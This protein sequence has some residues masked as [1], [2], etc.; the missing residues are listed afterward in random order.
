M[1]LVT[2][3]MGRSVEVPE[4]AQRI[5]SLVP[6]QTEL[7]AD[8]GLEDEV[9]GITKF[10]VHPEKWFRS[11]A[12]IGG[13]KSVHTDRV[14]ALKPDL[15]IANKEENDKAQIEALECLAPVW[16]SD[17]RTLSEA[18]EMIRSIGTFCGKATEGNLIA[19]TVA[20]GFGALENSVKRTAAYGI[21]RAPWMWAGS[22]TF[23]N[24]LM[25]R[26]GLV[27]VLHDTRYPEVSL[28][29]LAALQ[30]DV[31]LLSSEPYPFKDAHITEVQSIL[32]EAKVALVDGEMFSWYGSRLLHAPEYLARLLQSL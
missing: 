13:T 5:V 1:P 11:K 31:V 10:C 2:D 8:L 3:M 26:C 18:L 22:D 4:K 23:I 25:Q 29:A 30:P 17:I 24:D 32:P 28:Q 6:S 16:V 15:I 27:N 12:R 7:L 19:E 9:V 14:A 20:D 21:W